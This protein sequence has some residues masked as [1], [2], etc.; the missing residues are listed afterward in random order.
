VAT[1]LVGGWLVRL[2]LG[3]WR[4]EILG[5]GAGRALVAVGAVSLLAQ[6]I[7]LGHE[8]GGL[9]FADEGTFL[10]EARRINELRALRPWFVYPHF[11]YYWD[12]LALWAADLCGPLVPLAARWI[13]RVEG[14]LNVAGLVTRCASG[15]LAALAPPAV[16][17]A[18]RRLTLGDAEDDRSAATRGALVA[19][20]LLAL[21]PTFIEVG[22][23]NISD[24]PAAAFAAATAYGVALL[25]TRETTRSYV[26]PASLPGRRGQV[27]GGLVALAIAAV[28]LR[29]VRIVASTAD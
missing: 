24:V 26:W 29:G 6:G 16:F 19:G 1:V 14:E 23:L 27:P 10:A 12:A 11:L 4:G 17:L 9:Y 8:I 20:L 21:S 18:A 25:L 2:T 22:H 15:L 3:L 5:R 28:W 13:W 7:G